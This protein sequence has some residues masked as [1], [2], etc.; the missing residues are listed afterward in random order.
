M[1]RKT[2]VEP[3]TLVAPAKRG[4]EG[5]ASR[6]TNLDLRELQGSRQL[7]PLRGA[8]V[9]LSLEGFLQAADLL[10]GEGGAR[11]PLPPAAP[12]RRRGPAALRA[13]ALALVARGLVGAEPA[14][15]GGCREEEEEQR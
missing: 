14:A 12:V 6:G 9:L 2:G 13:R 8:Q 10:R 7:P 3:P 11:P 15:V 5:P 1:L 4:R